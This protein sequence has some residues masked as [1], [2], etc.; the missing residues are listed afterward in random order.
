MA[1]V[2]ENI[3]TIATGINTIKSN[4]GLPTNT[5]LA[6]TVAGTSGVVKPIGTLEI[7][8]NGTYDVTNYANADVNVEGSGGEGIVHPSF[9]SFYRGG[10]TSLDLS[11]LRTDNIT[12]MR[13]MFNS[14]N[15][16]TLD[17]SLFD[18][19]NVTN[20]AYMFSNNQS[21][22]TITVGNNFDTSKVADMSYMYSSATKQNS[23][24]DTSYLNLDM[25]ENMSYMYYQN[26]AS[27][28]KLPLKTKTTTKKAT[29]FYNMFSYMQYVTQMENLDCLDDSNVT[30]ERNM[31]F[32]NSR[33][34]SLNLSTLTGNKTTSCYY[35]FARCSQ[36]RELLLP[37]FKAPLSTSFEQMFAYDGVLQ[38]IDLSSVGQTN[39]ISCSQMFR[40]N[41][42]I[43]EILLPNFKNSSTNSAQSINMMFYSCSKLQKID[44][45]NF[46]FTKVTNYAS[47][48]NGV[49]VA[50]Q[51]IVKDATQK[52]WLQG[53]FTTLTNIVTPD[54]L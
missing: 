39:V 44:I 18:T 38:K 19:R 40:A 3:Q 54:E 6:N 51:I 53:K 43:T 7:T 36:L 4:L 33:L 20:M 2:A 42:S 47:A 22:T 32:Y 31:F 23:P 17:L 45:R 25:A 50:C 37:N 52:A 30:D 46:D 5:S 16:T 35:M 27:S 10:A 49:P 29:S 26:F 13:D 28:L 34:T 21:L 15:F 41:S 24:L 8:E 48:F 14:N 1:T 9:V 11:W 12:N